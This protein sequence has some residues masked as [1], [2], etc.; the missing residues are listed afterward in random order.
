MLDTYVS[1]YSIGV[2]ALWS[3]LQNL[4][5]SLLDA[6][7]WFNSGFSVL[8]GVVLLLYASGEFVQ[9]W[10]NWSRAKRTAMTALLTLVLLAIVLMAIVSSQG[11]IFAWKALPNDS[12]LKANDFLNRILF[13]ST[14][15]Y[16]LILLKYIRNMSVGLADLA[17]ALCTKMPSRDFFIDKKTGEPDVFV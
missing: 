3:V 17:P 16:A 10:R 2:I 6:S 15:A 13:V 7:Y 1:L 8:A 9:A 11:P 12:M 4:H 14:A 5:F